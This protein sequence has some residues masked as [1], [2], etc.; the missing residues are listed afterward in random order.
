MVDK[1][2]AGSG[3]GLANVMGL[4]MELP[5]ALSLEATREWNLVA[6]KVQRLVLRKARL[7]GPM[8]EHC[9]EY[10]LVR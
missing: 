4:K 3:F 7:K 6:Q 9:L 2:D 10:R 5:K 8:R 1:K